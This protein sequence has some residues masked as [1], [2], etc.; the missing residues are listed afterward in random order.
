[1]KH[2]KFT[3][4]IALFVLLPFTPVSAIP[5][6]AQ[7]PVQASAADAPTIHQVA[8]RLLDAMGTHKV[9][10]DNIGDMIDNGKR[11]MMQQHPE[12]DPAFS[13]VWSRRMHARVNMDDFLNVI[14]AIYEKHFT[15]SELTVMIGMYHD[16]SEQ[17]TPHL[18]D[19]FKAKLNNVMPEIQSEMV[20]DLMKLIEKLGNEV[21][22]SVAKDHPEYVKASHTAEP[23]SQQ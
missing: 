19:A 7:A 6:L 2:L 17:R 16:L 13:E 14:A 15:T 20:T 23:A 5:A 21:T 1:M 22:I 12:L 18:S 10:T 3:S 11:K 8:L 9:L 4:A